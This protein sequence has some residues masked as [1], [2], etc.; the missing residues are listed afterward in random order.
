[1]AALPS[2]I[3]GAAIAQRTFAEIDELQRDPERIGRAV[4]DTLARGAFAGPQ[5]GR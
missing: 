3:L 1:M 5:A 4:V 2:M